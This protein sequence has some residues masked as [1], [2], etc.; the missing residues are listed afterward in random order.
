M[1][2]MRIAIEAQL[3]RLASP[4]LTAF[5]FPL[6]AACALLAANRVASPTLLM[7]L[8]FGVLTLN[9]AAAIIVHARFRHDVWLLVFHLALLSLIALFC[10]A[11]LTHFQGQCDIT[12]GFWFDGEMHQV[13]AGVFH[14]ENYRQLRFSNAGFVEKPADGEYFGGL[15]NR[16]AWIGGSTS[17]APQSGVI[18][19]DQPLIL[20][21]YRIYPTA[22]MGY[23]P[24]LVWRP[25][26]GP[27]ESGSVQLPSVGRD[28]FAR[29]ATWTLADGTELWAVIN[30]KQPNS[31]S[32]RANLETDQWDHTLVVRTKDARVEL[33]PGESGRLGNGTLTYVRLESWL[34][35]FVNYDPTRPWLI[36]VILIAVVSLVGYYVQRLSRLGSAGL[37]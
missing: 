24:L 5:F 36:A 14:G 9:L 4:Y 1:L 29:G 31:T 27:E 3:K 28:D 10:V 22:I 35:Y 18:S 16:V 23:A 37:E 6:I 32:A 34:G 30:D 19:E 2:L 15:I 20:A 33:A 17:G 8:P 26:H 11:R 7:V 12:R 25:D 21:G 13:K